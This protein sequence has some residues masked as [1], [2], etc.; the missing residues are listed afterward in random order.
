MLNIMRFWLDM[1]IDGFRVDA[2]PYLCTIPFAK[3]HY[4]NIAQLRKKEPIVKTYRRLTITSR[5][6]EL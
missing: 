3:L 6:C 2:V 5:E 4:T 1:G